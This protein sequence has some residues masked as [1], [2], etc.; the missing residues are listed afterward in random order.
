MDRPEDIETNP[1]T[2]K[3]YVV[4]TNNSLRG[5]PGQPGTDPANVIA[6]NAHGH[7]IEITEE[8]NNPAATSFKWEIF[9]RCGDPAKDEHNSYLT[10]D[11]SK[12]SAL[13]CPDNIVFDRKGNLWIA[14]DGQ[15]NSL[16]KNDGIYAVP[17][18]GP[19][20]GYVRQFLS[21]CAGAELTSLA[22]TPD[23]R[24]LFAA[25]Q[26]PGEGSKNLEPANII[27]R[28]PDGDFP[29]PSVVAVTKADIIGS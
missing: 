3:V 19:D 25:I 17:V 12:V 2:G 11:K 6:R 27:S 24:S 5:A 20:R 15:P 22:M 13:S 21:A 16:K 10:C 29:R 23:D 9:M 26:H 4:C 8:S 14:T 7:I 1:I 18:R 28:W